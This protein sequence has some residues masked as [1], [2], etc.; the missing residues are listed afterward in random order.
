MDEKNSFI[1][2]IGLFTLAYLVQF[3]YT[4]LKGAHIFANCIQKY[5]NVARILTLLSLYIL[6]F[7][8]ETFFIRSD[9]AIVY[10]GRYIAYSIVFAIDSYEN[11]FNLTLPYQTSLMVSFTTLIETVLLAV[12]TITSANGRWIWFSLSLLWFTIGFFKIFLLAIH[13]GNVHGWRHFLVLLRLSYYVVWFVSSAGSDLISRDD[14]ALYY[15]ILDF[16]FLIL[17]NT[18]LICFVPNSDIPSTKRKTKK[19]KSDHP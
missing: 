17:F 5:P 7:F 9:D 8:E 14:E 6:L 3:V 1:L 13:N 15:F 19:P 10:Y 16:V 4:F 18:Q 2:G 12:A 11:C